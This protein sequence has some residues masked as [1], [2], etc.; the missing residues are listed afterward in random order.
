MRSVVCRLHTREHL[1]PTNHLCHPMQR[2]LL[3]QIA[4]YRRG[5]VHSIMES[6]AA[7]SKP[8]DRDADAVWQDIA[9][10]SSHRKG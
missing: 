1:E 4:T 2:R 9:V 6:A 7:E 10:S 3:W 8:I 5:Q